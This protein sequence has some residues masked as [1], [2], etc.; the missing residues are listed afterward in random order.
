[1]SGL[2]WLD[3]AWGELPLPGGPIAWDRLQLQLDDGTD[4]SVTRARRR[5]GAGA[6]TVEGYAVGP[7]GTAARLGGSIEME[8]ARIWRDRGA[9]YPVAWRLAG[10]GLDLSVAPL[11][12][13][14]VQDFV[15][16]LWSGVVTAEGV[17]GD[18]PATGVGTLNL[19]GYEGR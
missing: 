14:Q 11:L 1:V 19:T 3:H 15:A 16:L 6:A 4:L 8:P 5:S 2:A 7:G 12:D 9:A 17:L 18:R 10:N 13:D